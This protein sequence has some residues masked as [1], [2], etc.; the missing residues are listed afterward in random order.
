MDTKL[1]KREKAEIKCRF[2]NKALY[3]LIH[4]IASRIQYTEPAFTLSTEE[5]FCCVADTLDT[6][7]EKE[8]TRECE[9]YIDAIYRE[10]YNATQQHLVAAAIVFVASALLSISRHPSAMQYAM[11]LQN[12]IDDPALCN[13]TLLLEHT[14]KAMKAHWGNEDRLKWRQYYRSDDYL[15]EQIAQEIQKVRDFDYICMDRLEQYGLISYEAF[16]EEFRYAAEKDA[17]TLARFMRKYEQLGIL[18]FHGD[19]KKNILAKLQAYFPTMKHY[20]YKNFTAA[21]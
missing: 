2:E 16:M 3:Q 13:T 18:N 15:T 17:P 11:R 4:D 20:E 8:G 21:Y 1:S 9:V 7:R 12:S 10:I 19:T 6:I 5:M 14:Q